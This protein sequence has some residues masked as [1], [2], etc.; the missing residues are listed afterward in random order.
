MRT[1]YNTWH[2]LL[3]VEQPHP[4]LGHCFITG[5]HIS[6]VLIPLRKDPVLSGVLFDSL[7]TAWDHNV[8]EFCLKRPHDHAV[9]IK[10]LN[11]AKECASFFFAFWWRNMIQRENLKQ[12]NSS[13]PFQNFYLDF[14]LTLYF[15]YIIFPIYVSVAVFCGFFFLFVCFKF[16]GFSSFLLIILKVCCFLFVLPVT[17][18]V[19]GCQQ[20]WLKT[21]LGPSGEKLLSQASLT[22]KCSSRSAKIWLLLFLLVILLN[23]HWEHS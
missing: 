22:E 5:W 6:V 12:T 20:K 3:K 1:W 10:A 8:S 9:T 13:S 7:T 14:S 17:A 18:V 4:S 16:F 23:K 11:C 21:H 2:H 15:L 19:T